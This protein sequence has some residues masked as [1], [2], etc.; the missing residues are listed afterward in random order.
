METAA[1]ALVAK[2]Y[3]IPFIGIRVLSNT[4]LHGEEFE[5]QT[6]IHCQ[7]FVIEYTKKLIAGLEGK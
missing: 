5:P 2:A 7:Q 3:A 6:A 1:A 4:D